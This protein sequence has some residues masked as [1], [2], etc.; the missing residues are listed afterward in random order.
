MSWYAPHLEAS[1]RMIQEYAVNTTSSIIDIGGGAST[2][3]R[4][5]LE[6]GFNNITVL[7]I[8][9]SALDILRQNLGDLGS[10]VKYICSDVTEEGVLPV[11]TF[12]VWHDRAVFHFL[13][14]EHLR[15][16]YVA[17]ILESVVPGGYIILAPFGPEGPTRCSG[18]DVERYSSDKLQQVLGERFELVTSFLD[19]HSTPFGTTQQF[20]YCLFRLK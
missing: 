3:P 6:K 20:N 18:L 8:S 2:L 7:D 13:T 15:Q 17:R 4:D 1:L 14:E 16:A 5:L 11:H 19:Y 10:Q 9:Q 12:Q